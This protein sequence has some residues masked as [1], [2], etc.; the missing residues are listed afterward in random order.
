[1]S[2][3]TPA[4]KLAESVNQ[5]HKTEQPQSQTQSLMELVKRQAAEIDRRGQM[6]MTLEETAK[7]QQENLEKLAKQNREL[8]L[9]V[10][11]MRNERKNLVEE[12][13]LLTTQYNFF[14]NHCYDHV[15]IFCKKPLNTIK[16]TINRIIE[17]VKED[18]N[19]K[20]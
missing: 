20:E 12:I 8:E 1:M 16:N 14:Y 13:E 19:E 15:P 18:D 4:E 6:I 10:D 2:N 17:L 3:K 7:L 11:S 5:M 9:L